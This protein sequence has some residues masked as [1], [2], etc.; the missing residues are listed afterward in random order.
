MS[1]QNERQAAGGRLAEVS[2]AVV[3]IFS[4]CYGRGPTKAKTYAFDNYV[5]TVLEEIF[6]TVEETLIANGQHELVRQVRLTFQDAVR[7]R[8][9][10]AVSAAMGRKVISYHSQVIFDPPTGIEFFILEDE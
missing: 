3:G 8:F 7:D 6:T 1:V 5:V 9:T 2:N 4:E 10:H